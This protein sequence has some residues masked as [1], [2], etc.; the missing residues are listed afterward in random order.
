M[1]NMNAAGLVLSTTGLSE[2]RILC[3][4][5]CRGSESKASHKRKQNTL[6]TFFARMLTASGP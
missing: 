4:Q 6:C 1:V 2:F 3:H 5:V